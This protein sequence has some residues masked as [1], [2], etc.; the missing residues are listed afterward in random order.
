MPATSGQHDVVAGPNEAF[1]DDPEVETR[2]VLGNKQAGHLGDA[3]THADTKA[4]DARL[5]DF[6]LRLTDPVAVADADVA[7]TKAADGEVLPELT[8]PQVVATQKVLPVAIRLGLVDHHGALFP[9]VPGEVTLAVAVDVEPAH[10]HGSLDRGLADSCVNRL[11]VPRH[12]L[13]HADVHGNQPGAHAASSGQRF[14]AVD[15]QRNTAKEAVRHREQHSACH[16]LTRSG[17]T[18]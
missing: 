15:P 2:A 13:G 10:H 7:I 12:I 8:R 17:S 14:T 16:V 3:E 6:E 18:P 9:T 1:R 5:G 4:G 11:A